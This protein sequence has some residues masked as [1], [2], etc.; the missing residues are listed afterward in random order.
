MA[1]RGLAIHGW[2]HA[3]CKTKISQCIPFFS[4]YFI[5][6]KILGLCAVSSIEEP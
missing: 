5:I 1:S 3:L 2:F 6:A 4:Y